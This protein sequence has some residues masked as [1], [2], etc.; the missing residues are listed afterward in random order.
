MSA[1]AINAV[2]PSPIPEELRALASREPEKPF[3]PRHIWYTIYASGYGWVQAVRDGQTATGLR[4]MKRIEAAEIMVVGVRGIWFRAHMENFGWMD[5]TWAAEGDF[6]TV[7]QPNSSL[8]MEALSLGLPDGDLCAEVYVQNFAWQGKRCSSDS[9]DR[10]VTVGTT[11]HSLQ[12]E[13]L[14]LTIT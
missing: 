13:A 3:G 2:S 9:P 8:R 7:G 11:G 1:E 12:L 10:I 5:W 6:T 4:G 14:T